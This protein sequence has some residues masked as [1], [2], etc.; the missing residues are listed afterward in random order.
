METHLLFIIIILAYLQ[1]PRPSLSMAPD[2][3]IIAQQDREEQMMQYH[4][5][6]AKY[7]PRQRAAQRQSAI[8]LP[9]PP[10]QTSV[11]PESAQGPASNVRLQLDDLS[12]EDMGTPVNQ[13]DEKIT[14]IGKWLGSLAGKRLGFAIYRLQ[15]QI[16]FAGGVVFSVRAFS[17]PLTSNC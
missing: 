3:I 7:N 4:Q 2:D 6:L 5:Q 14:F 11:S 12:S 9:T 15:V 1:L 13:Q 17:K 10:I 16:C 8:Q